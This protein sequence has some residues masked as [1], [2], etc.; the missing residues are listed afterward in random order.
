MPAARGE[1]SERAR[2]RCTCIY[3]KVKSYW[4]PT[5]EWT[6]TIYG[7]VA[8]YTTRLNRKDRLKNMRGAPP[9][10]AMLADVEFHSAISSVYQCVTWPL[11][12]ELSSLVLGV[13]WYGLRVK[14]S[15]YQLLWY[16]VVILFN[17]ISSGYTLITIHEL[18]PWIFFVFYIVFLITGILETN[19]EQVSSLL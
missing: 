8:H 16:S 9:K 15:I 11:R 17:G 18:K 1:E 7:I 19:V 5:N 13:L 10:I 6:V 14:M 12:H 4:G 3:N 2:E